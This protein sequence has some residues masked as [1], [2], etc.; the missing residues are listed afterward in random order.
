MKTLQVRLH[1]EK[2][3]LDQVDEFKSKNGFSSKA[4]CITEILEDRF[5][6]DVKKARKEEDLIPF[7]LKLTRNNHRILNLLMVTN[8]F[9]NI[10]DVITDIMNSH[11][12]RKKWIEADER[13]KIKI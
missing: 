6:E 10:S 1:I 9:D 5:K 7:E 8:G 3:L 4:K 12:N 13:L 2:D 11:Q